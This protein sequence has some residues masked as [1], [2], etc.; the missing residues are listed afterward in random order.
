MKNRRLYYG[1]G[2]KYNAPDG[3]AILLVPYSLHQERL[4]NIL[5]QH[6]LDAV[7]HNFIIHKVSRLSTYAR[8]Y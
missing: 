1:N 7:A 5:A 6:E 4:P 2:V 8:V 3:S